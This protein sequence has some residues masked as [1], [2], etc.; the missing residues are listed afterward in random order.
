M[1]SSSRPSQ[2]SEWE[3][4]G[5]GL[6]VT[7][8]VIGLAGALVAAG[9]HFLTGRYSDWAVIV[10]AGDAHAHDGGP[11]EAFDNARRDVSAGF[12]SLGFKHANVLQFSTEP[13]HYPDTRPLSADPLTIGNS[14]V[15]LVKRTHGGCLIY[16]SSH[17]TPYGMVL[18]NT[19]VAP[20]Q[21][22]TLIDNTCGQRPTV[23]VIS[24][25]Y[26]GAFVPALSDDNRM[27]L[28]AS[29]ADRSSFGCGQDDKYPY[30]DT[31]VVQNLPASRDFAQLAKAVI[32]C[33]AAREKQTGASPPSEP[34]L[35]I[36][37]KV[38]AALPPWH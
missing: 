29:R 23:V 35:S 19:V 30:F 33:V 9:Y 37:S 27:I 36:G 21:L 1:S 4:Y 15:D 18:G 28:T 22:E 26:S 12:E 3:R 14:L 31:C 6:W 16:F 32:G 25:C 34:Q 5:R 11:S 2:L 10:V 7:L 8:V 24:A 38:A 17:G 13:G 20:D